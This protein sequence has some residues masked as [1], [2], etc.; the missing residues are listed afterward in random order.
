[1]NEDEFDEFYGRD[2][3]TEIDQLDDK[4]KEIAEA[5]PEKEK[6][7]FMNATCHLN[8]SC[9]H[10]ATHLGEVL[11][12]TPRNKYKDI[13]NQMLDDLS[14][15]FDW[16]INQVDGMRHPDFDEDEDYTEIDDLFQALRDSVLENKF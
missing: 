12:L 1:M 6:T 9:F 2:R 13:I 16:E 4:I 14:Q 11:M 5:L 3:D 8:N 7:L 15:F 10:V